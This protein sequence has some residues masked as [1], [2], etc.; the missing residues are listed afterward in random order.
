[1]QLIIHLVPKTT[2]EKDTF[3]ESDAFNHLIQ[4]IKFSEFLAFS[5]S[6][7]SDYNISSCETSCHSTSWFG[8]SNGI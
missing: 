4:T 2:R 5:F 6:T 1:M 3:A 7:I 8:S